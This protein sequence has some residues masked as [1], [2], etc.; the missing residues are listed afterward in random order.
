MGVSLLLLSLPWVF[1]YT[2]VRD[3]GCALCTSYFGI[4]HG[5]KE[6]QEAPRKNSYHHITYCI[7]NDTFDGGRLVWTSS[8]F[9]PI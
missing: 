9:S 7:A 8:P 6:G 5:H 3:G 1:M 4:Q 2:Q